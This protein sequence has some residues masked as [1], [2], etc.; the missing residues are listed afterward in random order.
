MQVIKSS[1]HDLA[2]IRHEEQLF[3]AEGHWKQ[4]DIFIGADYFF[5]FLP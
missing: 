2:R 5:D 3:E 4:P 1:S